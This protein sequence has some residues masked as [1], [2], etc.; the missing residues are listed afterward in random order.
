M[1]CHKLSGVFAS[2]SFRYKELIFIATGHL[3]VR[4]ETIKV[5][6]GLKLDTQTL[7]DARIIPYITSVDVVTDMDRHDID[8]KIWGNIWSDF[9]A[10]FEVFFV[11]TVADAINDAITTGLTTGIPYYANLGL[12]S[13]DGYLSLPIP[14]W[15]V[16]WETAASAVITETYLGVGIK[17]N[18]F[19]DLIGEEDPSITIPTLPVHM[20]EHA[21][22]FQAY[23]ST[24]ALDTAFASFL[25]LQ[26]LGGW[27][28]SSVIPATS[29][30][31]LTT[32]DLNTVF[33]GIED[34]Y[35]ADLPVDLH[36][37]FDTIGN[38]NIE[39]ANEI[40]TAFSNVTLELWVQKD[41]ASDLA[42]SVDSLD[43]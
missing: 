28:Y 36:Y 27:L 7:G 39:E 33:P 38:F 23:V 17:G 41:G 37:R 29:P 16:D 24:Y 8:I 40:M 42:L 4:I 10:A 30:F 3:E 18:F 43:T 20:D 13:T 5:Q 14:D 6:F 2:S 21:E 26:K 19:D 22:E 31:Q 35:G 15:T 25:D 1:K 32:T 12:T 34:Q 9:A 11:G